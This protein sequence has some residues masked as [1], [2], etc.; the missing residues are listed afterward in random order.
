MIPRGREQQS[1]RRADE[2]D[3]VVDP[4]RKPDT[5][6][7]VLKN[8]LAA[9]VIRLLRHD[10]GI[11]LDDGDPE[12]VHQARV[13]IRRF[14]TIL[15]EFKSLFDDQWND[16]LREEA[17]SLADALGHVRDADVM[18]ARQQQHID[19]IPFDERSMALTIMNRLHSERD[20]A[21]DRLLATFHDPGYGRLLDDMI[22]AARQ[23][24]F[25][26]PAEGSAKSLLEFAVTAFG[27]L[28]NGV[29]ALDPEAQPS[30]LHRIRISTKRARY[31]AEAL[32]PVAGKGARRFA[33][34]AS[35]LQDV[36]G[37]LQDATVAAEWLRGFA[38]STP[39]ASF[40]AGEFAGMEIL[41]GSDALA[42]WRGAWEKLD[43]KRN[44]SWLDA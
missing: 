25:I 44:T 39:N 27:K 23:P 21:R 30:D 10:E 43:R 38:E 36:L 2:A 20:G 40:I 33:K 28:R 8:A 5:V 17:K 4:K 1:G 9:A 29:E 6:A 42:R 12:H 32:A 15:K 18:I 16:V 26:A 37:E 41:A 11:R 35:Q 34:Q 31:V 22:A 13:G 14:R 7:D 24:R 3:L 19:V